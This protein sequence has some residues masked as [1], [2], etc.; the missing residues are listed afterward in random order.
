MTKE[1]GRENNL[2][3]RIQRVLKDWDSIED[4]R[5]AICAA[6][7][8]SDRRLTKEEKE[9]G[10]RLSGRDYQSPKI[11]NLCNRPDCNDMCTGIQD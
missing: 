2:A 5:G 10:V 6:L 7:Y 3:D 1:M 9:Q 11:C 4:H 8:V